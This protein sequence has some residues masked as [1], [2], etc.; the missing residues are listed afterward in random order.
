MKKGKNLLLLGA[1]ALGL[2]ACGPQASNST[3]GSGSSK[4]NNK[5]YD[6]LVWEDQSKSVGIEEAVKAFEEEHDVTVKVVE[7]AYAD[8]L[9]DLRLDG[10]AGTGA[11]VI[12]IPGDQIGTAVTEGLLKEMDV[13]QAIQ[14]IYTEAA[15]QSQIV[16][17]K[18]YGLPKAVETQILY[19][20]KALISES[21]LPETTDEWLTYSKKVTTDNS[22][23]LLALWDQIYYAQGVLSG[24]GGYVFGSDADGNY[25]PEDI[26]LANSGAI[27]GA[28]YIKT[29]YDSGVFPTGIVGEQ[30]IN[31][32]DSLFTEGKAAA[33]ISGPWN[34][35]PYEEAGIDYGVKELPMLANGE[36]MGSFIGVKSYNVSSYSKNTDLAEEFVAFIANEENS[37]TR[38]EKTAEIPAVEALANDPAILDSESAT[39]IATQS[40]YAELTP[41]ITAMNSVWEPIDSAL[42]TI[43][44]GKA[45]PKTALPQAVEQIKSAI[46][47]TQN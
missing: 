37:K 35:T 23:G 32:L 3:D 44:T 6:L 4:G 18:V 40:K 43:A 27:K 33:V 7:K 17:G 20:N 19:Y 41:G 28:E 38:F 24:Y 10:P 11:D 30:G 22:Y 31:V 12:T 29:F 9:E 13:E 42:Q 47:A 16:D 46:A 8:Q 36:H 39:A 5:D 1:L 14:D 34:L 21:D 25:D 15:M 2:S 45:E 26:G